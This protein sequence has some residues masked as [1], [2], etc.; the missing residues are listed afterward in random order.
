MTGRKYILAGTLIL[1]L[2]A[3]SITTTPAA[4][5][6]LGAARGRAG[7]ARLLGIRGVAGQLNLTPDQKSQI[8]TILK[9]DQSQILQ[10]IRD[11]VKARLDLI[12]GLPESAAELAGAQARAESL[13]KQVLEQI[14]PV[15]TADQQAKLQNRQQLREQRL[16]RLLDRL[17]GRIGG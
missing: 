15:L 4:A 7:L 12:K 1:A 17:N 13:R 2:A 3:I 8:K 6:D 9:S 5:Q 16:Q 10:A 11:V 14:R